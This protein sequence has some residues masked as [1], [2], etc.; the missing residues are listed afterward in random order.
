MNSQSKKSYESNGKKSNQNKIIPE[1]VG[2]D[3]KIEN[4]SRSVLDAYFEK[5]PSSSNKKDNK[6]QNIKNKN[7]VSSSKTGSKDI[8][9]EHIEGSK[10]QNINENPRK[11]IT[12][13][14]NIDVETLKDIKEN[15]EKLNDDL[16]MAVM[17][18]ENTID[19][20]FQVKEIS[21]QPVDPEK[22]LKLVAQLK[23]KEKSDRKSSLGSVNQFNK[24]D[25]Y[26]QQPKKK[27]ESSRKSV[28]K[29]RVPGSSV[30]KKNTKKIMIQSPEKGKRSDEMSEMKNASIRARKASSYKKTSGAF[31]YT[32]EIAKAPVGTENETGKH[33]VI[34][35]V[36]HSRRII[37]SK[38]IK[39]SIDR[40]ILESGDYV[41]KP[42]DYENLE[43][44][45][46][47]TKNL[48]SILHRKAT[49]YK[50]EKQIEEEPNINEGKNQDDVKEFITIEQ[51]IIGKVVDPNVNK[52]D[53]YAVVSLTKKG[54]RKYGSKTAISPLKKFNSTEGKKAKEDLES[55]Q[56]RYGDNISYLPLNQEVIGRSSKIANNKE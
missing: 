4:Q 30:Q 20:Y 25:T 28:L 44:L 50:S 18:P 23:A 33:H 21:N 27:K 56:K 31:C 12:P 47:K 48:K 11:N 40:K 55:V 19:K 10:N 6:S 1:A 46:D 29:K 17:H 2:D 24:I 52:G 13:E 14:K 42:N 43:P 15:S 41:F 3:Q 26:Y 37:D 49:P 7:H 53:N 16:M 5:S 8:P 38:K 54:E 9:T 32:Y 35:P 39:N 34:T 51:N 22:G 36:K 45:D